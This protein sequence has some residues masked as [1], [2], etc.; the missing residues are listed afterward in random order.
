MDWFII[1]AV[2]FPMLGGVACYYIGI[3]NKALRDVAAVIV[4]ALALIC[5]VLAGG[6][7]EIINVLGM[8]IYFEITPMQKVL[9][10]LTSAI[11][12]GSELF[13]RDYMAKLH[14]RNRY[15]LFSLLTLGATQGVFMSGDLF[16]TFVFFEMM[17]FTSYVAVKQ[18][19]DARAIRAGQTYLGIAVGCGMATLTGLFLLYSKIGTLRFDEMFAAAAAYGNRNVIF[20]SAVLILIGFG[21]KVG[22]FPV[23]VWLPET[24]CASPAPFSAILSCIL[25]KTGA[26]GALVVSCKL[27]M[28]DADWGMLVTVLGTIT[29]LLG[30]VLALLS[31]ELKRTLACSS[32]S[33]IGFILVGIGML[34]LLGEEGKLAMDGTIGHIVNHSVIKFVLFTVAGVIAM[35]KGTQ[36]LNKLRGY[37]RNKPLLMVTFLLA[38]VSV[39][40][41]PGFGGYIS[42]TL[43][44][45]S[46]VEYGAI[47]FIEWMFIIAGGFTLAYMTKLFV[48]IFVEHGAGEEPRG[49]KYLAPSA[50][51]VL[52]IG[53]AIMPVFG[54]LPDMTLGRIGTISQS[55]MGGAGEANGVQYFSAVNIIGALK[56]IAIGILLYVIVVRHVLMRDGEYVDLNPKWLSIENG[57][58]R[59]L[60]TKILPAIGLVIARIPNSLADGCVALMNKCIFNQ[61]GVVTPPREN[62]YFGKYGDEPFLRKGFTDTLAFSFL[63]LGIC[64]VVSMIY[65]ISRVI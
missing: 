29:M 22:M 8:G 59:P 35:N 52:V 57:I 49:Q 39:S 11:W 27:M 17:S 36:D 24:Y 47:A 37:G 53:A 51:V 5:A 21:A 55:F 2:F 19:Q 42:K 45:E 60:V 13:A 40:G 6:S 4:C 50:A 23:H 28:F 1:P 14:G 56:S 9:A 3:K 16:T 54:L 10:I 61:D 48:C 46:I 63:L 38:A 64:V 7:L 34:G 25:S 62:G 12:L 26:F 15:H 18:T 31:T 65:I 43:L 58:Y 44:H 20:A 41:I 33:Q 32:L 30:A